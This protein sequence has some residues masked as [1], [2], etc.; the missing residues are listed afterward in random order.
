MPQSNADIEAQIAK[1]MTSLSDQSKPNFAKTAR[2]FSVPVSRLRRRWNGGKSLFERQPN[3]RKLNSIQELALRQ[4]I[5]SFDQAGSSVNRAQITAAANSIL[6]ESHTDTSTEPPKIGEHWLGRFLKRNPQYHRIL[7]TSSPC[8]DSGTP[9]TTEK[10]R[11]LGAYLNS[12]DDH[13][14]RFQRALDKL[15]KSAEIQALLANELQREFDNT[16]AIMDARHAQ[17]EASRRRVPVSGIANK[18]QLKPIKRKGYKLTK[19][20]EIK[21]RRDKWPKVFAL[22]QKARAYAK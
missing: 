1:A 5:D 19:G 3:G 11:G 22:D 17:Y 4:F 16:K 8:T 7:S 2:E 9:K 10:D 12:Y 15:K 13:C 18:N 20:A 21:K 6:E 14:S